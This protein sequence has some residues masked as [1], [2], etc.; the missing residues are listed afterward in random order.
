[1]LTHKSDKAWEQLGTIEPY[2]GVLASNE[3]CQTHLD[4]QA[5][6]KFFESGRSYIDFV[7]RTVRTHL[8]PAF[9]PTKALDFGCGVGRLTIPLATVCDAVTGVDVSQS[10]LQEA[11]NN[12]RLRG[13]TNV[14]LITSDDHLQMVAGEFDFINSYVVFQHIIPKRGE[15]IIK[16]LIELLREDGVAVLHV[17]YF[18]KRSKATRLVSWACESMPF[19]NGICNRLFLNR[20]FGFPAVQMNEYNLGRLFRILYENDCHHCY[21]RY[22][23]HSSATSSN[24][25]LVIF[26]QKKRLCVP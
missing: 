11:E 13:V 25:G 14:E 18:R 15:I 7:L 22:T 2:Y 10:M 21:V 1:M 23:N 20:P 24:Y 5:V 26:F 4:Q 17:I 16:R 8:D 3:Y 9:R 6:A 19:V 12:C